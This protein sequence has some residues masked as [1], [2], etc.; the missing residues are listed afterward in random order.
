MANCMSPLCSLLLLLLAAAWSCDAYVQLTNDNQLLFA[1]K[2]WKTFDEAVDFCESMGGSLVQDES[3]SWRGI[4]QYAKL[5]VVLFWVGAKRDADGVYRW[6]NSSHP[7]AERMWCTN[8]PDCD[9]GKECAVAIG[10]VN[11]DK[12]NRFPTK[13][14]HGYVA[15]PA[16]QKSALMC[17]FDTK[18]RQRM[19][20]LRQHINRMSSYDRSYL[21]VYGFFKNLGLEPLE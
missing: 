21:K 1:A 13:F 2:E 16:T 20:L 3:D 4:M 15:V 9:D 19:A 8:E 17:S 11:L 5:E 7:F 18:D 14:C 6:I 10:T 12:Y